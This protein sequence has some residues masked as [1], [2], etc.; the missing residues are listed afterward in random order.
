MDIASFA[1][2]LYYTTI[3][4]WL[5]PPIRQFRGK[6]FLFFLIIALI[7]PI[8]FIYNSVNPS[9]VHTY[10]Y[11]AGFSLLFFSLIKGE[12]R[13]KFLPLLIAALALFYL[14][15]YF[16][17]EKVN[18]FIL[19]FLNL[20]IFVLLLKEF[21]VESVQNKSINFFYV[22]LLFYILTN[23]L[24][25][26]NCFIGLTDAVGQYIITTIFQAVAG[27]FFTVFRSDNP[28]ITTNI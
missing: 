20:A 3:A 9:N 18:V 14:P 12:Y 22:V 16:E 8:A 27:L 17:Y 13:K 2:T 21:I 7:D 11:I 23:I 6:F 10:Y 24:K 15:A 1:K 4:I 25:L 19:A 28:R 5:L 26:T